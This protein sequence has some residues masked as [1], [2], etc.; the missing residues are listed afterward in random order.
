MLGLMAALA[1]TPAVAAPGPAAPATRR[2]VADGHFLKL[3]GPDTPTDDEPFVYRGDTAWNFLLRANASE[4]AEYFEQ[5]GRQGFNAVQAVATGMGMGGFEPMEW[6]P[7]A[8]RNG[9]FAWLDHDGKRVPSPPMINHSFHGNA[10]RT[11]DVT[12]H[13]PAFWAHIDEILD[14]AAAHGF[15]VALWATWGSSFISKGGGQYSFHLFSEPEQGFAHGRF[16]GRRFG[17]RPN[18]IFV[19]GGD[20]ALPVDPA[21]QVCSLSAASLASSALPRDKLVFAHASGGHL[22]GNGRGPGPGRRRGSERQPPC[23]PPQ[24]A[25]R[26]RRALAQPAHDA[27][28]NL[29]PL[30]LV[31]VRRRRLA[32][33]QHDPS[34]LEEPGKYR[35]SIDLE[36]L[37]CSVTR[38]ACQAKIEPLEESDF[39]ANG[40]DGIRPTFMGEGA[41]E[42]DCYTWCGQ[43]ALGADLP[44]TGAWGVRLYAWWGMLAG[45][46][47]CKRSSPFAPVFRSLTTCCCRRR[48]IRIGRDVGVARHQQRP[49]H[50]HAVVQR[51][52]PVQLA[53]GG[54]RFPRRRQPA[55]SRRP[56]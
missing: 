1:A 7:Q 27:P 48:R 43:P 41:Y 33:D 15:Y 19:L 38:T 47:G 18:L 25:R 35:E 12:K 26:Q 2:L 52:C 37:A 45:G 50:R 46:V 13:N 34:W 32:L 36:D 40:A 16:I 8:D 31:R 55:P 21:P 42:R 5:R 11:F 20:I 56:L 6:G 44:T 39:E 30:L 14:V 49:R 3:Q 29:R 54:V 23:P 10:S 17:A 53:R 9:E 24:V 51:V 22:Q 28:P 4:A